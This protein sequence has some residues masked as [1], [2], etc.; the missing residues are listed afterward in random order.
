MKRRWTL[1]GFALIALVGLLLIAANVGYTSGDCQYCK[2]NEELQTYDCAWYE[3]PGWFLCNPGINCS[4][5][6]P[7]NLPQ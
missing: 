4:G 5:L 7:C 1:R 3:G 2:W 6:S